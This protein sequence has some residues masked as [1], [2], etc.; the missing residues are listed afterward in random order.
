MT[1]KIMDLSINEHNCA[2]AWIAW[3]GGSEPLPFHA[4]SSLEARL[5][6][7]LMDAQ[8]AAFRAFWGKEP[9]TDVRE[10]YWRRARYDAHATVRAGC[11]QAN[12]GVATFEEKT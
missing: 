7:A 12:N 10:I 11:I 4:V 3:T 6:N 5:V 9:G 8:V 1:D 2:L